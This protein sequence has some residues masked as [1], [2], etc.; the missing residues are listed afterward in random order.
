M[1]EPAIEN[2]NADRK[3]MRSEIHRT[4]EAILDSALISERKL[5]I[6][7]TTENQHGAATRIRNQDLPVPIHRDPCRLSKERTG[8]TYSAKFK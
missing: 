5:K 2:N 6:P 3:A 8:F 7:V 1:V 4:H